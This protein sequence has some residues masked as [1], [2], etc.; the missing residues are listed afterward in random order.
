MPLRK[1]KDLA[2]ALLVRG[3]ANAMQSWCYSLY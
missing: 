3:A 2:R 1:L